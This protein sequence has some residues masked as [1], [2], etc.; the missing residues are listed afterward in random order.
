MKWVN[1]KEGPYEV[2]KSHVRRSPQAVVT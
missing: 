1:I 2:R